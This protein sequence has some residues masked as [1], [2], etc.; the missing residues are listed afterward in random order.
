M[1]CFP[2]N[3]LIVKGD[4][5]NLLSV[6]S[7]Q[8]NQISSLTVTDSTQVPI[9]GPYDFG[10]HRIVDGIVELANKNGI[11][12]NSILGRRRNLFCL[13]RAFAGGQNAKDDQCHTLCKHLHPSPNN[14]RISQQ[15]PEKP[16]KLA[17]NNFKTRY[18]PKNTELS[19]F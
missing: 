8:A 3:V 14:S 6:T 4:G 5:T 12:R 15:L 13:G 11:Y 17:K 2:V 18:L 9:V 10:D 7:K 19:S 16:A 1:E